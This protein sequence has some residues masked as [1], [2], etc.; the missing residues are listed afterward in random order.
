V[1]TKRLTLS[2]KAAPRE[3]DQ[4]VR[5]G[6]SHRGAEGI[7]KGDLYTARLTLDIT[8]E[9]RRSIKLA[10]IAGSKTVAD[11][12]REVLEREFANSPVSQR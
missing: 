5:R 10:A 4:W 9:L 12:L 1:T 2:A 7:A 3:A 11:L 8:P 6:D